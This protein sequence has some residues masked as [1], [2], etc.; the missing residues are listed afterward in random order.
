ME[1]YTK[2]YNDLNSQLQKFII[3]FDKNPNSKTAKKVSDI[4][5]KMNALSDSEKFS[6]EFLEQLDESY[7]NQIRGIRSKTSFLNDFY[8]TRNELRNGKL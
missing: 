7:A 3:E 8:I 5:A 6:V 4:R 1:K 2:T